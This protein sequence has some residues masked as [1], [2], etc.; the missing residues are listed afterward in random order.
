MHYF[1]KYNLDLV[2]KYN[3]QLFVSFFNFIF[4]YCIL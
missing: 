4:D 2:G 1:T 3:F